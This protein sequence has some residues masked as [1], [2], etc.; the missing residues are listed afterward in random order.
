MSAPQRGRKKC[1]HNRQRT[2]CKDCGGVAS[3][4]ILTTTREQPETYARVFFKHKSARHWD[5]ANNIETRCKD[6]GGTRERRAS[7]AQAPGGKR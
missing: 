2:R 6:C 3:A 7:K 5:I 4:R 1:E